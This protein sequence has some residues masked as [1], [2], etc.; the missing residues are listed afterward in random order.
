MSAFKKLRRKNNEMNLHNQMQDE[1][2]GLDAP[3][4]EEAKLKR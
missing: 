2:L 4:D 3:K 1:S